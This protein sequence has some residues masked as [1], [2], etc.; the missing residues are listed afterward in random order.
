MVPG[1]VNWQ[2]SPTGLAGWKA[3][4]EAL[5]AYTTQVPWL[6]RGLFARLAL[7]HW[8]AGGEGIGWLA[9]GPG[10]GL[11]GTLG[12]EHLLDVLPKAG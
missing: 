9:A 12:K 1:L 6:G 2:L 3:K 8:V 4:R 11:T 10:F 5:N 7:Y